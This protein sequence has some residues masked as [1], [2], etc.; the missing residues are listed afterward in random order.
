MDIVKR[1]N[2]LLKK[3]LI[4]HIA[5]DKSTRAEIF[6]L[7]R[8]ADELS[9]KSME[10]TGEYSQKLFRAQCE[11]NQK[12]QQYIEKITFLE[13]ELKHKNIEYDKIKQEVHDLK[14]IKDKY[15]SKLE[16]NIFVIQQFEHKLND[17]IELKLNLSNS[18]KHLA[19]QVMY[20]NYIESMYTNQCIKIINS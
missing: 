17:E 5:Q 18:N 6:I 19:I 9:K 4:Q 16:Q 12:E 10:Q 7:S 14:L 15:E 20:N 3:Q 11:F 1:E 8:K 2:E 13:Q